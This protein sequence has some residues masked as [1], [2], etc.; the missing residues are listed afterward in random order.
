MGKKTNSTTDK[1][2]RMGI[3]SIR[4]KLIILGA[5]A[6]IATVILG[7]TGI[8][9]INSNN[10]NNMLLADINNINLLQ[11]ENEKLDVSFLYTLDNTDNEQILSNLQS[12]NAYAEDAL[13][14][15][16]GNFSNDLTEIS[17]DINNNISNMETL[18][19]L[20]A[21]R[22]F[23][24]ETGLNAKYIEQDATIQQSLDMMAAEAEWVDGAWSELDLSQIET[25]EIDGTTYAHI[26]YSIDAPQM[27]KRNYLIV[28]LGN[29]GIEY[30]GQIFITDVKFDSTV[31]DLSALTVESL[32]KSYGTGY[33]D[34]AIAQFN[35]S[36]AISYNGTFTGANADW[37]EASIEIPIDNYSP[38]NAS[39]V[40][41]ELYL[42]TTETPIVKVA[43]AFNEKYAF[44]ANI[45]TLASLFS[46]YSKLIAE[47]TNDAAKTEAL[48]SK[49]QELKENIALYSANEEA[50]NMAVTAF[51]E[52]EAALNQMLEM[53]KQILELKASN[54]Q[55]N[56]A[57][58]E[59]I[60][61][62]RQSI[63]TDTEA[64]K[65]TMLTLIIAVFVISVILIIAL[66]SFVASSVQKSIKGFKTTLHTIAEGNMTAKVKTGTKDEF[67][68]FGH[69]LNNM[70]AKLT[71]TL[72][73]VISA[74]RDMKQSGGNLEEMAQM[75]SDTSA[76]IELSISGI[77]DGAN[78]QAQ[79]VEES[80]NRMSDLG[81]LMDEMIANVT[82]LDNTS[83][84]MKNASEQAGEILSE[85]NESNVKMTDSISK[86]AE[87]INTT[88]NSVQEI[89]EAVSLISSIANQTNLLSLNASIEA[90][91]AGEAGRGFAVVAS[92]IQG[93][94]EQS[95]QSANIIYK[96]ITNLANDF[97]KTMAVMEEV[98][99]ATAEQNEKLNETKNK[100]EIV[101][102]GVS[103]SRNKTSTIKSSIEKCNNVRVEVNRLMLNLAA[104][105]EEN[106][107]STT[108]TADSMQTLNTTIKELLK[109]SEKL[110][111]I[112]ENLENDMKFFVL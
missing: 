67:D 84:S 27:S 87:Q 96:V 37:Q 35:G 52:K 31:V 14:Q 55:L 83:I 12:M 2:V 94:A 100:F 30:N 5:V 57:M 93:L 111:V 8:K 106:A 11:N 7:L 40:S 107:A 104:I 71:D 39:K 22:G 4:S 82:D 61:Q 102:E 81:E 56:A 17:E 50:V 74:A 92:E 76:Q 44:E 38:Q 18:V 24:N 63:E 103:S 78:E 68:D 88:N 13:A 42:E 110:N 6:I 29:N 105:S 26:S 53:D 28:R 70:T 43:A 59:A 1:N 54:N 10:V 45:E 33:K 20:F 72:Q 79:D 41:F 73:A 15:S 91:R 21:D 60:K 112:A 95:N 62:V 108:E 64:S 99:V 3:R 97:Q 25:V 9:L 47:G 75:T 90:A 101:G 69:S 23:S 86:I 48:Q 98:Q 46:S 36:P 16:N 109:A 85:L 77:S 34:L 51:T 49:F 89:R 80:T 65:N 58:T 66:T 19:G 32:S